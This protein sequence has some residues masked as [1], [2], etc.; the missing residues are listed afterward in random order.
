MSLKAESVP[1]SL[2][3][4]P[5]AARRAPRAEDLGAWW[6]TKMDVAGA[7]GSPG[8][9]DRVSNPPDGAFDYQSF[10][11]S[12][13]DVSTVTTTDGI[14]RYVS[15]ACLR[16]F[17]WDAAELEG[18]HQEDFVHPDDVASLHAEKDGLAAGKASTTSYRFLCR[19]G[20][21]R[22]S[23]TTSRR[24]IADGIGLV[25]STVRDVEQRRKSDATLQR[26]AFTD[27][28]TGVANRTVLIDRLRQGLRRLSRGTG[29]L[30]VLYV[31]LDR[32]KVINDSLGHRIG[33]S[34]L[35]KMAERLTHHLRP[36]DTLARLGGDEF[37]IIAEGI[38][39]EQAAIYLGNRII[40]A[41]HQAFQFGDEEFVCTLSVGIAWT[42]DFQRGAE[43]LLQ[44]ADLALY[45]AKDRG[46][47]R[48]ELFDE[49]LRTKAVG[50]LGTE[51]MLRRA[52]DEQRLVVEYQ[53]I[54]DL[55]TGHLSGAEALVRIRDSERGLLQPE[56]FLEVAEESGLLIAMDEQVMTDAVQ[57]GSDWQARFAGADLA[58][59]AINITARHLADA[60]FPQ[61]L[62]EQLDAR[63]VAHRNLQIEVTERVLMEASNSAMTGL[64]TLRDVDVQ[65]GL[66]D[67]GTGYS[68]LAYLRQ[69][70]LDFVK[71]DKS[72][73]NGLDRTD[74]DR[75]IVAATIGLCHALDLVVVAEGVETQSQLRLLES[76]ECDRMQG[77]LLA[78]SG[79]PTAVEELVVSGSIPALRPGSE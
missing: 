28:L 39:D 72:F 43:D 51:R 25:V 35:L 10:I 63:G 57:R 13:A 3:Q 52:L 6:V 68:S 20:S 59:V 31:D 21:Y 29:V 55:H 32:F 48:V 33:D 70:P 49:E 47:D 71:I 66:D 22:W 40:E 5:L 34:V 62:I 41:G 24:V 65:V 50:R 38:G 14:Y 73:I 45:R 64:R 11:G 15:P 9:A 44:E 56:S 17:G 12:S 61:A 77:F 23:E 8:P 67:F 79:E 69:F 19:D 46:R 4:A 53:P 16:L 60:R 26:Q 76:L 42:T 1:I 58:E 36:A 37:V 30:A 75:A 27:P 54:L 7:S 74:S 18:H 2:G 78:A